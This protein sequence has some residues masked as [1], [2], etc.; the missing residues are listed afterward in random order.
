MRDLFLKD[1][2]WKLFS[3]ALAIAIWF[4]VHRIVVESPSPKDSGNFSTFTYGNLPISLV[5]ATGD[6]RQYRALQPSVSVTL[7][8]PRD[9]VGTLQ[10]NQIHALVDL[11]ATNN[12]H[13]EKQRVE[14][15]VPPGVTVTSIRPETVGIQAPPMNH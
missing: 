1:W 4:T 5:S 15:A 11:T 9:L 12:I 14:V 13:N 10:A 2:A 8:V 6:T 7:I 3:L